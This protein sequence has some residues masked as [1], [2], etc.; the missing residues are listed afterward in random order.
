MRNRRLRWAV[1]TS[2]GYP[3][4]EMENSLAAMNITSPSLRVSDIPSMKWT[5]CRLSEFQWGVRLTRSRRSS[6][7]G[8]SCLL[9]VLLLG[10]AGCGN[11]TLVNPAFENTV[12]G[13][14]FPLTPGPLAGF[15]LV[16]VKNETIDP[17]EFVVTIQQEV[18]RRN[19]DGTL[20][21]SPD[22]DGGVLSETERKTVFLDTSPN[23]QG[24]DI[25]VLF[26][27]AEVLIT[28]VGL[29]ENLLSTDA[30]AFVG[31]G[32]AGGATGFGIPVGSLNPLSFQANNFDCGDTII[33]R[34]LQSVGVPGGVSIQ[35]NL[36][37]ADEQPS[38]F[39]GPST[40]V[41]YEE[42][43]ESQV[44]EDEP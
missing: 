15:L 34:A 18:P 4:N 44:R 33:F 9:A 21:P 35:P 43:L 31:G 32:G 5:R 8:L 41:N 12:S 7:C 1:A 3:F 23:G 30:A 13:G 42:F 14:V 28:F 26:P 38:E 24:S 37:P 11:L 10:F 19:E 2:F 16:R 20:V 36:L 17:I 39:S 6:S 40:F 27:C 25:G 22:P 29:G